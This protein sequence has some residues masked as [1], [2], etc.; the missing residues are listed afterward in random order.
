MIAYLFVALA[1]MFNAVMDRVEYPAAFNQSIFKKKNPN[2]WLKTESWQHAKKIFAYKFDC[3]HIAK[4]LM[5]FCFA[6]AIAFMDMSHWWVVKF[7]TVGGIWIVV[8]NVF[9]NRI[10][11]SNET[12]KEG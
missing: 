4:S 5:L 9:Y 12:T 2:F 1:A 7:I 10:L 6:F 8:F 3:W 11:K